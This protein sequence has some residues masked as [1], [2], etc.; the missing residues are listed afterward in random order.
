MSKLAPTLLLLFFRQRKIFNKTF[1]NQNAAWA[2]LRNSRKNLC[3]EEQNLICRSG[4]QIFRKW[5]LNERFQM[6]L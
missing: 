5:S 4:E 2:N 3:S 6:G 1:R